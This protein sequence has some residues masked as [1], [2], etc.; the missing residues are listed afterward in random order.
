MAVVFTVRIVVTDC[1]AIIFLEHA[2]IN[3]RQIVVGDAPVLI[4]P[5]FAA[6]QA[7]PAFLGDLTG[8]I[9]DFSISHDRSW[10]K[11]LIAL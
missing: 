10:L 4:R 5:D 7:V 9:N 3:I 1:T 2:A 11:Q 8:V 6:H